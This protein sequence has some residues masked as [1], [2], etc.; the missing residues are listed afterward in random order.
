MQVCP[1]AGSSQAVAPDTTGA[2]ERGLIDL[3]QAQTSTH[4]V[5]NA[6]A[7]KLSPRQQA[8]ALKSVLLA[9]LVPGPGW[10]VAPELELTNWAEEWTALT[11]SQ[12][13][14]PP[15]F[16]VWEFCPPMI[17]EDRPGGVSFCWVISETMLPVTESLS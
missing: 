10:D 6:S 16:Q 4:P 13:V 3:S 8:S 7:T 15:S 17:N 9:D 2:F 1:A 14:R 11:D 12:S 5:V